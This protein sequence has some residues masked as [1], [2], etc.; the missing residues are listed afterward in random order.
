MLLRKSAVI[1]VLLLATGCQQAASHSSG[2]EGNASLLNRGKYLVTIMA[3]ADCHNTGN[4][5]PNPEKGYLQGATVGFEIPGMGIFY[6]P[7]L[8]PD[9]TAGIGTWSEADIVT[10]L[11][12]GKTP[13]GR[14]LAPVMPS[15]HYAA[16][17]D[18]DA[19][20]IAAYLKSL[21]PSPN[22]VSPPAAKDKAPQPYL[23]VVPPAGPAE[24]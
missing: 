12:T 6:P 13:D 7:N 24:H 17:T 8:T 5:S 22:K 4:F 9:R 23:T 15:R 2:T 16:L 14:E 3:C 11:R 20:A 21:P 18:E 1:F 19:K 10:A